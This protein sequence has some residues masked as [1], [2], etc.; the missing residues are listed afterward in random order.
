[1]EFLREYLGCFR[2]RTLDAPALVG[3]GLVG[4]LANVGFVGLD[5]VVVVVVVVVLGGVGVA[6]SETQ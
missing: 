2:L 4:L 3:V 5:V 1:M 6:A